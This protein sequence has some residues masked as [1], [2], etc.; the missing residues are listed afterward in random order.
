MYTTAYHSSVC[1]VKKKIFNVPEANQIKIASREREGENIITYYCPPVCL[2][3]YHQ[4]LNLLSLAEV[5]EVPSFFTLDYIELMWLIRV[6]L[7][8]VKT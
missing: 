1:L 3:L 4:L 6:L 8:C 5:S 2:R 7:H